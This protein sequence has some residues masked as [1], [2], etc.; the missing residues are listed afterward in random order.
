MK[1]RVAAL[2]MIACAMLALTAC[3]KGNAANDVPVAAQ[4]KDTSKDMGVAPLPQ[5]VKGS[6]KVN[7]DSSFPEKAAY[8]I[9]ASVG[10][11][12]RHMK[13]AQAEFIGPM[14]NETIL[15]GFQEALVGA[16]SLDHADV[17]A[18]LRAL[19][20]KVQEGLSKKA[21]EE[22]AKNLEEG[23]KFL[24]DHAK[25]DGVKVTESGLQYRV[26]K[27]GDGDT[28]KKGDTITVK[29][30]GTTIDG[31]VFDE[32]KEPVDFPLEH[33]IEGWVE[34]LQLMKVGSVYE[35]TIP[36]K[37][38]YGEHGAGEMIKP[39]SVLNF[40]VELVGI[41]SKAGE[42]AEVKA[43]EKA[44][45]QAEVKAEEKAEP[46]AEVKAE[47]KAEPQAEVKAEEKAEPQAEVKAEEKAEPQ[48]EVKAEEKTEPKAEEQA[49]E[50]A[51]Q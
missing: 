51:A 17:E 34:G 19:D 23:K 49:G 50:Q 32:A 22:A 27:E 30:K 16:E 40:E 21:K 13:D 41:K 18:T 2:S 46:Q 25:Q 12:L 11:Y 42:K 5:A 35:L 7:K 26:I 33:M 43:E 1:K 28:P 8:S 36:S 39:N 45:P 14:D 4:K 20:E 31:K 9:G 15:L 10:A 47:E 6:G 29:Y 24:E 48:A 3:D 44:E 38:G 37:L